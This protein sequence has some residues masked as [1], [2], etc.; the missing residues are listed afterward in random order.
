MNN[1]IFLLGLLV[2]STLTGL[3]TEAIKKQLDECGKS[4]KSNLLAGIVALVLSAALSVGYTV[5]TEMA[6]TSQLVVASVALML[7]SWLSAMLGYDKVI[8]AISQFK[9]D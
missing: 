7:L 1:S 8:Q 5:I 9:Q 3:V 2:V 6:W 4:Y